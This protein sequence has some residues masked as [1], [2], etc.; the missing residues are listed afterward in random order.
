MTHGQQGRR[1][2]REEDEATLRYLTLDHKGQQMFSLHVFIL[3]HSSHVLSHLLWWL[4]CNECS[5]I[6]LLHM[7]HTA[8]YITT[9]AKYVL[10]DCCPTSHW[11]SISL[12]LLVFI[13]ISH[14]S[15]SS[16]SVVYMSVIALECCVDCQSCYHSYACM[17]PP[18]LVGQHLA[19]DPLLW[20]LCTP[21]HCVYLILS[22]GGI[23]CRHLSRNGNFVCGELKRL[24]KARGVSGIQRQLHRWV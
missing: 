3:T 12:Y 9:W 19:P 16:L 7:V 13:F 21:L 2:H 5:S 23:V 4:V 17:L 14:I 18:I 6:S 22:R 8:Y 24:P 11:L 1:N 10:C 20:G 15:W